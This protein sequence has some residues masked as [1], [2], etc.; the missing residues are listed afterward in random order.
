MS[1]QST[2]NEGNLNSVVIPPTAWWLPVHHPYQHQIT[3]ALTG[4]TF[5]DCSLLTI[6]KTDTLSSD[7]SF[8]FPQSKTARPPPAISLQLAN[9]LIH[10]FSLLAGIFRLWSSPF[11]WLFLEKINAISR[12][13]FLICS[14]CLITW[15]SSCFNSIIS[16]DI[17]WR[18]FACRP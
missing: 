4:A 12:H 18:P 9:L 15:G 6:L 13:L 17:Q 1:I 2:I 8:S 11:S 16:E 7:L 14:L 10:L 5:F 3:S